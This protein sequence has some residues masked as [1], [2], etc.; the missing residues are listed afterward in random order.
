MAGT[1][2]TEYMTTNRTAEDIRQEIRA[3][4]VAALGWNQPLNAGQLV[5]I[6]RLRQDLAVAK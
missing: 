5:M 4:E 1:W 6:E 2:L 3:I